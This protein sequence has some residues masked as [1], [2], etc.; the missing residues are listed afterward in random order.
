MNERPSIHERFRVNGTKQDNWLRRET[1]NEVGNDVIAFTAVH[2][3]PGDKLGYWG[4]LPLRTDLF[5]G[6][7]SLLWDQL[8]ASPAIYD[9]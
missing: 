5:I 3:T 4:K 9:I 1:G 8:A 6:K 2:S 7:D